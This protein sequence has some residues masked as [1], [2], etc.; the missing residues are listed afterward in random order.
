NTL[1]LQQLQC[2]SRFAAAGIVID[3]CGHLIVLSYGVW[4]SLYPDGGGCSISIR[5]A[6]KSLEWS[7]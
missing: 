2:L 4:P 6:L 7:I 3:L 1:F 5:Q